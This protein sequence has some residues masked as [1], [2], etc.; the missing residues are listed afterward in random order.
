MGARTEN[1]LIPFSFSVRIIGV[2]ASPERTLKDVSHHPRF[3][4]PFLANLILV[5][6]FWGVVYLKLGL[7]GM[8]VAVA[9]EFRRGTLVTQDQVDFALQFSRAM[10]LLV[11]IGS[12][13][14][15]LVHVLLFSWAGVRIARMLFDVKLRLRVA[16]SLACYAYLVKSVTWIVLSI[17][18]V[19]FGDVNGMNFGNLIPTNAAFFLDP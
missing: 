6:W 8:A 15:I 5:T 14:T 13:G 3:F 19:L 16:A 11:L 1:S 4:A 17:P 9:Q 2:F 12:A 18:V 10:P 7:T